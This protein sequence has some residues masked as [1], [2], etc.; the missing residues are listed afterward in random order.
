MA[1]N[2][3]VRFGLKNVYYAKRT[4][5]AGVV[6]YG[7]PVAIPGAVNLDLSPEG[8]TDPFYA[9]NTTYYVAQANNGYSGS[10]EVAKI[11]AAMYTD[12]WGFTA[13]SDVYTENADAEPASFALGFQIDGDSSDTFHLLYNV[14]A[15]RPNIGS[16]TIEA[17]K[18]PQTQT[19]D[20]T[21]IPD[22]NANVRKFEIGA[23]GTIASW[24]TTQLS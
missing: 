15:S 19:V 17:S 18:T 2:N 21:A 11:P 13:A 12:I 1:D 5:S 23:T 22:E 14:S 10:L 8:S 6:T 16:A 20:I 9:D 4:I 7:T 3:K 24:M